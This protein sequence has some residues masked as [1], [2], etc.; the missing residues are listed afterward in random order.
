[1]LHSNDESTVLRNLHGIDYQ[2]THIPPRL[3]ASKQFPLHSLMPNAC[4]LSKIDS[5]TISKHYGL[6]GFQSEKYTE[7][8]LPQGRYYNSIEEYDRHC[9]CPFTRTFTWNPEATWTTLRSG[10]FLQK[11]NRIEVIRF[12]TLQKPLY[13]LPNFHPKN[14]QGAIE[15]DAIHS[16][17]IKDISSILPF[18]IASFYETFT[19]V[20]WKL[21]VKHFENENNTY[22][23]TNNYSNI[24]DERLCRMHE[25]TLLLPFDYHT[26]FNIQNNKYIKSFPP[27][28]T[29]NFI[30]IQV[31]NVNTTKITIPGGKFR[32]MPIR[33]QR[34]LIH[35]GL[36]ESNIFQW[37]NWQLQ[38]SIKVPT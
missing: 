3:Q 25:Q 12:K 2:T 37:E 29:A 4:N 16:I 32:S 28:N 34:S 1:M 36:G 31:V 5:Y 19:W 24:F 13:N 27:C 35:L 9:T 8:Y 38:N 17:Y 20:K 14:F 30:N 21:Q 33:Q 23:T 11:T 10:E 7:L 6:V 15:I 26:R 22:M 18:I